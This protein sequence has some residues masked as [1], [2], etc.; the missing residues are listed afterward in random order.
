MLNYDI[1]NKTDEMCLHSGVSTPM[2]VETIE[3]G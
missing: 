1:T 2:V 3:E